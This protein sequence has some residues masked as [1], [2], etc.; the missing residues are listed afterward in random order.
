MLNNTLF[1][2]VLQ[3]CMEKKPRKSKKFN[4]SQTNENPEKIIFN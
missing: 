1:Y 2:L 3:N 4:N